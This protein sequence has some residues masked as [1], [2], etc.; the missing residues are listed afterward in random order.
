MLQ[1]ASGYGHSLAILDTA[2]GVG[3]ELIEGDKIPTLEPDEVEEHGGGSASGSGG[4]AKRKAGAGGGGRG[5]GKA[6]RGR[7]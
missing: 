7:K 5:K 2:S 1:V 3:K 6:K 4:A